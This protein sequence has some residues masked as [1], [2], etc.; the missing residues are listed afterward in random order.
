VTAAYAAPSAVGASRATSESDAPSTGERVRA[1]AALLG[2]G[3]VAVTSLLIG[4]GLLVT[5][6]LADGPIGRADLDATEWLAEHRMGTLD[7]WAVRLS[8]SAD[9]LAIIGAA[10]LVIIGLAIAKR[11]VD[12][13]VVAVGL[14]TELACF[15]S[16]NFVVNRPRPDVDH[17]GSVPT[18]SSFPSGHT[19]ATLVLYASIAVLASRSVRN[20]A[21][22]VFAWVLAVVMPLAVGFARVYRGMHAPLDVLAGMLMGVL[23]LTVALMAVRAAQEKGM[24]WNASPS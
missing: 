1:A 16:V 13:A 15:L 6:V 18:T 20:D 5:H 17:L 3:Y 24:R 7:F 23:A 19:A 2:V 22:R 8:R 21:A 12:I 14:T 9:T 4:I 11:W 10:T